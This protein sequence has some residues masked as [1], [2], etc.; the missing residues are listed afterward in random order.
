MGHIRLLA[1]TEHAAQSMKFASDKKIAELARKQ[2]MPAKSLPKRPTV[3]PLDRVENRV[4]N[5]WCLTS[6][7][8]RFQHIA[9]VDCLSSLSET[10][11][12]QIISGERSSLDISSFTHME[13]HE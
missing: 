4:E 6:T 12:E 1:D 9:Q 10:L 11:S 5:F 13:K 2:K 7:T 3:V 8:T